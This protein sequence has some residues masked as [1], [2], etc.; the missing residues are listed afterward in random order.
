MPAKAQWL[1][2]IPA[3]LAQLRSLDVPVVDRSGCEQIFGVRRRRA[4]ELMHQFGG[5]RSGNTVLLDRMDLI[6]Q[7]ELL[8][9]NPDVE[10]ERRRKERLGEKLENL[11]RSRAASA[12]RIPVIPAANGTLPTGVSF[13]GGEV[14]VLFAGVEQLLSTL[15]AVA[16]AAAADFDGF[17]AVAE[18]AQP[19]DP[20]SNNSRAGS[21]NAL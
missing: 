10:R 4:V 16:Q 14:R 19:S 6:R 17:R 18:S 9:S 13:V 1:Q 3:I 21:G 2:E 12:V 11:R 20:T 8:T 7:L 5:Y 15:Y